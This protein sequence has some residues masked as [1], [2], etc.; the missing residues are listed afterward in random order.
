MFA[1][2]HHAVLAGSKFNLKLYNIFKKTS[3]FSTLVS[4][5]LFYV[6]AYELVH[7]KRVLQVSDNTAN[8]HFL[9]TRKFYL[10]GGCLVFGP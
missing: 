10:T 8:F 9:D 6:M 3:V 7:S 1:G 4:H 2:H 5:F